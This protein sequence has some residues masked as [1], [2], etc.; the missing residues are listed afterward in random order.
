MAVVEFKNPSSLKIVLDL[1][2]VDGKAKTR[3]KSFSNLKHDAV[4]Q[5]VYDVGVALM[6][7]QKHDVVDII[8]VD[9]T[10]LS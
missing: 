5:D 1:G 4:L 10:T 7:L 8:K 9:N 3:S 2:L 6:G